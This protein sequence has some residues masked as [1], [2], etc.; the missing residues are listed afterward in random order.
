MKECD[1]F[2]SQYVKDG[3]G[4]SQCLGDACAEGFRLK[5]CINPAWVLVLFLRINKY[6]SG[7]FKI[8]TGDFYHSCVLLCPQGF[9]VDLDKREC[10]SKWRTIAF[11]ERFKTLFKPFEDRNKCCKKVP[12]TGRNPDVNISVK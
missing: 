6:I 1:N 7:F 5:Y 8:D 9:G 4:Y 3:S 10:L 2:D 11:Q 12:S